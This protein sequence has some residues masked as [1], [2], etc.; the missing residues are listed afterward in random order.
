MFGSSEDGSLGV[1]MGC[2]VAF[3]GELMQLP[4]AFSITKCNMMV[5]LNGGMCTYK[6][7]REKLV[8]LEGNRYICAF[9]KS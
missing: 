3:I 2:V 7:L 8:Y 6:I 9:V 1:C 4:C 5:A